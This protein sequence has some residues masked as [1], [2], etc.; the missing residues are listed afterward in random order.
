MATFQ[1]IK[2]GDQSRPTSSSFVIAANERMTNVSNIL[3]QRRESTEMQS[4]ES[5][6]IER[7]ETFE[8]LKN[9]SY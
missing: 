3:E 5:K 2:N 4:F 7:Q 1:V 6:M 8:K 9:K